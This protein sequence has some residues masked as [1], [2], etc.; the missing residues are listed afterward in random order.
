M[1]K[2]AA[3]PPLSSLFDKSNLPTAESSGSERRPSGAHLMK[4]WIISKC[5][6]WNVK[7]L[8]AAGADATITDSTGKSAVQQST[9]SDID[10]K[11]D[12][13]RKILQEALRIAAGRKT[14]R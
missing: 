9:S 3:N 10:P 14:L 7:A 5:Y 4:F 1:Y 6:K 8:L 11:C 12:R 2:F 13:C